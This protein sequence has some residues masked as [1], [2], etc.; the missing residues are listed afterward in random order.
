MKT[1][2]ILL[3]LPIMATSY[4]QFVDNSSEI[5]HT[6]WFDKYWI[7]DDFTPTKNI[8]ID[9]F[10]V[11]FIWT[12]DEE[13]VFENLVLEIHRSSP[14]GVLIGSIEYEPTYDL[15]LQDISIFNKPIYVLT[16]D[17]AGQLPELQNG[18][19]YWFVFKCWYSGLEPHTGWPECLEKE[20]ENGTS[21]AIHDRVEWRYLTTDLC[22]RINGDPAI[23]NDIEKTSLGEIKASFK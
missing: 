16:L 23:L 4:S 17:T 1:L 12:Y 5:M 21:A 9:S 8:N 20:L 10:G 11:Q 3:I 13:P 6:V 22:Y 15:S 19:D 7:C 14:I 18:I 2:V